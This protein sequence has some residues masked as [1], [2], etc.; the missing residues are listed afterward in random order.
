MGRVA[1]RLWDRCTCWWRLECLAYLWLLV[2]AS[3]GRLTPIEADS[4]GFTSQRSSGL[5]M[6]REL[7]C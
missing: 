6:G 4:S 5:A 2:R 1:G 3:G 7:C